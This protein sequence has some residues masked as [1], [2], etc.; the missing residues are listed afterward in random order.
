M[1]HTTTTQS[2]KSLNTFGMPVV[3][4][5]YIPLTTVDSVAQI[6]TPLLRSEKEVRVLGGGSNIL[7]TRDVHCAL[8][9][10]QF[11]EVRIISDTNT[12][13]SVAVEAGFNWHQWVLHS[14]DQGWYGLENLSL[15]PGN[16]GAAPIQNIGAY[17]VEVKDCIASVTYYDFDTLSFKTITNSACEFGYRNSVFKQSLKNKILITEV[18]FELSKIPKVNTQYG[19]IQSQLEANAIATPS[20]KD[21]SNAVISIRQSKLPNPADIGNAGSFFKNPVLAK[22]QAQEILKNHPNAPNY[23]AG[24]HVKLAAGW[25]IEQCGWKGKTLGNVGVHNKQALVLVNHGKGSGQEI[26]N[27]SQQ[28]LESVA[29]K[30][31]ITLEREVNIW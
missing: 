19:A 12:S 25:L 15:I 3:A 31:G 28:I 1:S 2:L 6:L 21:V 23:P 10:P 20:P 8:V 17:G 7:F 27:L 4:G 9:H 29:S 16:V 13:V 26:Y 18:V 30:F 14:I 5:N 24:D 22:D 11:K